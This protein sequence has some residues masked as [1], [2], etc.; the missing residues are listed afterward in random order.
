MADQINWRGPSGGAW[1]TPEN[2]I[3]QGAPA[4]RAPTFTDIAAFFPGTYTVTGGGS[5]STISLVDGAQPTLAGTGTEVYGAGLLS[6][7]TDTRFFVDN[8]VL[9]VSATRI[10]QNGI[11][12]LVNAP[13]GTGLAR[14]PGSASLG[15]VT[16]VGPPPP[17]GSPFPAPGGIL[18]IGTHNVTV[19]NVFNGNQGEGN[20]FNARAGILGT[21]TL[22][23][24]PNSD[25][26]EV[27]VL[28]DGKQ[29]TSLDFGTLHVGDAAT[30]HFTLENFAGN[31]GGPAAQ[32]ALQTTA[33]GGSIT[34][35]ALSGSGV[36]AQNFTLPGR[37]GSVEYAI[38]LDTSQAH[39]LDGQVLHIAYQFNHGRFDVGEDL[40]ITGQVLAAAAA[41]VDWNALAAKVEAAFAATGTWYVPDDSPAPPPQ[42]VDWNALAAQVE[43]N[44]A[45]TGT[46]YL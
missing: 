38:S 34:D 39:S 1:G 20:A 3:T 18:N 28:R 6:V 8:S 24:A 32:G 23:Q 9:V 16:L 42:S 31:A 29:V 37:G 25:H 27:Q 10:D 41:P 15:D 35:A 33:H 36:T 2:W 5:A 19:N 45:A 14:I 40:A 26:P 30:L 22:F 11:V 46:W 13:P 43:A 44:F 12:N 21:G 17:S 7:G 4:T